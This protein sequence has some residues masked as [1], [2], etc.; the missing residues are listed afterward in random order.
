[1]PSFH[2]PSWL[3]RIP[4]SIA[5]FLAILAWI[6][7]PAAIA[8]YSAWSYQARIQ[9][10]T[11]S[12]GAGVSENVTNF[13]VLVRLT[14]N[15]F[16]F[17]QAMPDGADIRFED[18]DGTALSYQIE[19]WDATNKL[20]E[21]WVK[22]PQV[23]GNSDR[24]YILMYWGRV[25]ATS[26]SS[27]S[28]VF[29]N[30][31]AVWHLGESPGASAPQFTD[32]S[33]NV[34]HGTAQGGATGDS[35]TAAVG[36]GYKLNGSSKY[37]S[38]AVSFA[39]P[40]TF[41]TSA[42]FKTTTASGG[43]IVGF[44][45][46]QTGSGGNRDRH[47]WMDNNGKLNFGTYNSAYQVLSYTGAAYNDGAWHQVATRISGSGKFIFVDGVQVAS[48][49]V[50]T[51]QNYT[52]YWR[53]GYVDVNGGSW[54]PTP[55]SNYLNGTLDEVWVSH[56][57]VSADFIKLAYQTQKPASTVLTYPNTALSTWTY[58]TKVYVNTTASGANVS[59]DQSN[60]P[61]L[62]RLTAA[63][64]NFSQ[65]NS[66]GS[67]LRFADSAGSLLSYEIERWDATNKQ[68]EIWVLLSTVKGNNNSQWFRIYWG[69][70]TATSLSSGGAVFQT[71]N[72]YA[73]VWH[74]NESSGNLL[75]ATV[76]GNSGAY[77]GNVPNRVDGLIGKAQDFDG[78]GD[79][80]SAGSHAS[81]DVSASD[82][83]TLSAWVRR[84]GA[85]VSGDA[86]GIVTKLAWNSGD[87]RN[88][89]LQYFNDGQGVSFI[90]SADG[91]GPGETFL[92]S[93]YSLTNGIWY[94]LAAVADNATLKIYVNGSQVASQAYT[95]GIFGHASS[96]ARIGLTDDNGSSD[97][98]YWNGVIDEAGISRTDRA[99]DW[100]KL[101]YETQKAGSSV[102]S[103]GARSG[104]FTKSLQLNF[105]TTSSGANVSG[106]VANIPILVRLTSSNFDFT[107]VR[108]DAADLR[109]LD[110]DG[111][112]LYHEVA[113]WD[114][115]NKTGK[116][117]VKVPQV[118]GNSTTDFITAYYG[119]ATCSG[120]AWAVKDS[121]W[122]SYLSVF[123]LNA[124]E[125]KAYDAGPLGNHGVF[126]KNQPII[127]GITG[128]N[129]AFFDGSSDY[130]AVPNEAQYDVTTNVTASAWIKVSAF[131]TAYQAV[132]GKGDES[133][134]LLRNNT[135]N[136]MTFAIN[137]SGG[138]SRST[139]TSVND[140]QWHQVVGTYD[141]ANLRIYLD[142]VQE[143]VDMAETGTITNNS[144][145]LWI[146]SQVDNPSRYWNGAISEMRIAN[147]TAVQSA[148]FIKLSYQNQKATDA[149]LSTPVTAASFTSSKVFRFNTTASGANVSGDVYNFPLLLRFTDATLI[150]AVQSG[151]PDIRFLDAD[152][153][154]WLDYQVERWDQA[155]DLAEVW[156]KVP[157]VDG[158]SAGD[159]ITMYYNDATNGAV[160]DGQCGACVFAPANAFSGVWHLNENGNNTAGGY[161]DATGNGYHGT[162]TNMD[163]DD[164][165]TA[166]AG[167]G[168]Q[169]NNAA[170]G[171][172]I[173][174]GTSAGSSGSQ[175]V[176]FWAVATA[177]AN[178]I[179]VDKNPN[180]ASGAGWCFKFRSD[181]SVWYRIGSES[182]HTDLQKTSGYAA[183]TWVHVTG[184]FDLATTTGRLYINGGLQVT[185]ASLAYRVNNTG[186]TLRIGYPSA[187]TTEKFPGKVD[188]LQ[189]STVA[190]DSNWVKLTYQTQRSDATPLFNPNVTDF[191]SSRK[192]TFNTTLTGANVMGDVENFPL[193]VRLTGSAL[194]DA[195]Q[196][197]YDD[198]RFLDGDGKTWLQYQVER[199]DKTQDSA[200]V[201][202]LV[203]KVDGNSDR[204]FITLYYDDVTNAAVPNGQCAACV[205][206]TASAVTAAWHM[207][208]NGGATV[209]EAI[210][211][212][213]DGTYRSTTTSENTSNHTVGGTIGN[214]LDFQGGTAGAGQRNNFIHA[215]TVNR[216]FG[217]VSH[218]VRPSGIRDMV[219]YYE[220][221]NSGENGFSGGNVYEH[222]LGAL[223]TGKYMAI[224]QDGSGTA[225]SI[226]GGTAAANTWAHVAMTWN[227]SDSLRL[228]VDGVKVA[229]GNLA[230]T[231]F[232]GF[233]TTMRQV[234]RVPTGDDTRHWYGRIDEIQVSN[235][236]RSADWLK[237]AYETQRSSGNLFWNNRPGP[238]N[239]AT[240]TATPGS[241]SIS[242]SWTIPVSDSAN[243]DSVGL[244][245]KYSG[246]PDSVG[247]TGQ[248]KVVLLPKTD[249]VYAYPAT[250]P[251]TYTFALAVRNGSGQWSPFTAT[252]TDTVQQMGSTGFTDT[253]YVDSAIGSDANSCAQAQSPATPK[254]T[255]GNADDC[256][257]TSNDTLVIRVL[258][259]TYA[260]DAIFDSD[261]DPIVVASFDNNSRAVFSYPSGS[262]THNSVNYKPTLL[263]YNDVTVRNLDILA[264][265]NGGTG[266]MTKNTADHNNSIEGCR[267][268]NNGNTKHAWGIVLP[269]TAGNNQH[270]ANNIIHQPTSIGILSEKDD[271]I[272]I[273]NNTL[274]G[275][276]SAGGKGIHFTTAAVSADM[277]IT[278]NILYNWDYGIQ[279]VSN[280]AA[281]GVVSNN[282][283][284]LVTS[285]REL[286]T[287]TDANKVIKDPLFYSTD[288]RNP[289]GFKLLPGS[290]ALDAGT[291]TRD[292]GYSAKTVPYDLWGT[293]RAQG[294]AVDI[295][296]YE[297]TG[298]TPTP[299]AAFDTLTNVVS[300]NT[301]IVKNSKWKL[302]WDMARG[303]GI[304]GFYDMTGDTTANLTASSSLLFDVRI[305]GYLASTQTSNAIAP[306]FYERTRARSVIRQRLALSPS[307]DLNVWYTVH[308]SGH[309]YIQSEISNLSGGTLDV[310]AVQYFLKLGAATALTQSAGS[311]ASIS[312]KNGYGFLNT[313]SKDALLAVTRDLDEGALGASETWSQV[314]S[315]AGSTDS[316]GF[317]IADMTDLPQWMK[318]HH[319]FLLYVGDGSLDN[320]KASTLNADAYNPSPVT[321]SAGS[322]LHERSW[323]D[324]LGGHWN[325]DEGGGTTVKDRSINYTNDA[326]ITSGTWVSGK[327]GGALRFTTSSVATVS[328]HDALEAGQSRMYM[329]WVKPDFSAMGADAF[330]LSKGTGTSDGW[331]FRRVSGANQI[332][333]Q[334]GAV[335]VSSPTL[336]TNTWV[337]L[338]ASI[339]GPRTVVLYVNG[340]MAASSTTAATLTA[341]ANALR[342]GEN[343]GGGAADRFAGDIDDVRIYHSIPP[344]GQLQAIV[345]QGFSAQYGHYHLRAD[346]NNR[347]VA[348]L[349]GTT[350]QTR[351]QPAFKIDNWF[352]PKTPKHVY[353]NGVRLVPNVDFVADSVPNASSTWDFGPSLVL[354]LN[355]VLTGSTQTLFID[356]NDS[357]GYLGTAGKMKSLT[358]SAVANDKLIVKNFADTVFGSA[359]SGQWY[360]ELDLNGWT[361][362]TASRVT[363][364]G[365]GEF[366]SWKA[367][368][369]SPN[370]AVSSATQ[371]VGSHFEAGRALATMKFHN[372]ETIYASGKG[373]AGPANITYTL[374]DSSS[375]RLSLTL[376]A[377]TIQGTGR[378]I[379]LTKRWTVYPTGRI[380]GS[381]LISSSDFAL[382]EPQVR[383]ITRFNSAAITWANATSTAN[384]R[385]ALSGG[386][387]NFHS[388]AGALLSVKSA[389]VTSSSPGTLLASTLQSSS[390]S[391]GADYLATRLMMATTLFEATDDPITINFVADISRD[392]TDSATADSLMKDVQTPATLTAVGAGTANP[393]D[394]LDFNTTAADGFAEGDGAY[395]YTAGA[396]TAHFKFVNTVTHFNP[397]FRIKSWT[398]STLPEFVI[399]DNQT[400]VKDYQY[401]AYVNVSSNELI[402]QFNKTFTPGTHLFYISHKTGLAVTLNR[403]EALG[404][405]GVDSLAWST[406]SEF[407]NLGFNVWRRAAPK[408]PLPDSLFAGE[409]ADSA[410]SGEDTLPSHHLTA[411]QLAVLG[412]VRLNAKL[413][414]GAPGGSSATTRAYRFVD[415]TAAFG[416]AYEYL[417]EAV[418]F[419]GSKVQYGPRAATPGNPL[420][421]AL[422][423]NYPNPF[424]PVTTLRFSLKE[425]ARISL[426][427]YDARGRLVRTLIRP[428]KAMLP[429]RYRLLWDARDDGGFQV[430][431]GQY[432][433]RFSVPKYSKTRKMILVQ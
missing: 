360:T 150:D 245:V 323:Q 44:A 7:P 308:A 403:F 33:G 69:K 172:Y 151:A 158:N 79:Y 341:N 116:V 329:L 316:V 328:D 345:G 319:H 176:S 270:I 120:N 324:Q 390:T 61:L 295:G 373:Y 266:I 430:P 227:T 27:G 198:I 292:D 284:H 93:S 269:G 340:V 170:D 135:G 42:W 293:A 246:K 383:F 297:G 389:N 119:C 23:D 375:T 13:P 310:D 50:T 43:G 410:G 394:A 225:V 275:D 123:H 372:G 132:L 367:A 130:V 309:V 366:N 218:W 145:A 405:D 40:T 288:I 364:T 173:A 207:A 146:G 265:Q 347:V 144:D 88:Y 152:G 281:T 422:L 97:R 301:V 291:T 285:G 428:D 354:Q 398:F 425:K 22:V 133:F 307:L 2:P 95:G 206:G 257:N 171:E 57:E 392:F 202:V 344:I 226:N 81:L 196:N 53:A 420:E 185:D 346:N 6:L 378:N 249:S 399:V 110:K 41:T 162:G 298:Y 72:N 300:G 37:V 391:G 255:V 241:G 193:L 287:V 333:F 100:I 325:F 189:I 67:D 271:H 85:S 137:T 104:D 51:P 118:D 157:K 277:T 229:S 326:T 402:L 4:G 209:D 352:A 200:E 357:S 409:A 304:A 66:D 115:G 244:W 267:I 112:A 239:K 129:A 321:V 339:D 414:P 356:D 406:E 397:A 159:F 48:D 208:D 237:L 46:N 82:K 368:A 274:I 80:A 408:Q 363:D 153:V 217:T 34:N 276:G 10:N 98:Q 259:G 210:G 350:A 111:T 427:V 76:N 62:V 376:A 54:S 24:D 204:D 268:Y 21:V 3:C 411:E 343:A 106:N 233:A 242:L 387:L 365:F 377:M 348:V 211:S 320:S 282:L 15:N 78:N 305:D 165:V 303:G 429:G 125:D 205:F 184:T 236:V 182:A 349:N 113:E 180:D 192:L 260:G 154:T 35:L 164:D 149:L 124:P 11:T 160:P 12:S 283:F 400:L 407:E 279:T 74:L 163:S 419:S 16:I 311:L 59:T 432:F 371:L 148:N 342:M 91:T 127:N 299:T 9:F 361:T 418:D 327:V 220:G 197:D 256:A 296:A 243:A 18:P 306:V 415:R 122:N 178:Q 201:W 223:G 396:G 426:I 175:T 431:S 49:G 250:Y 231:T 381:F 26:E 140:G 433:Y 174:A 73:G 14:S 424:N 335:S 386:D 20:A 313:A 302:V 114:K 362:P 121:V 254:L 107:A 63:N 32:A 70:G 315:I 52:G 194:V 195:V 168:S 421:T 17:S 423:P 139:S 355:K 330:L 179:P 108:D 186:T 263:L 337:H 251:M 213:N 155:N 247:A 134:R 156:V 102:V 84:D 238:N 161:A 393:S 413:L 177:A 358:L 312:Y 336:A 280:T 264:G 203:P 222:H 224:Y 92:T 75:D 351:V 109:F 31:K 65:A 382:D 36:K 359:T 404:G 228:Y 278:N 1:M 190:R 248:T 331:H 261:F 45:A 212:T 232:S 369:V 318:R 77:A 103:V 71:A 380:F 38:S 25:S 322:L 388:L 395:V 384:G 252:S 273:M 401:N 141:G 272:N 338:A 56:T 86:E 90:V 19:R 235:Q 89:A 58:N 143:D 117:W 253:I 142:G 136:T 379:T 412:Y 290:P 417:L 199:W 96:A 68:A 240:L 219:T 370:L 8:D 188:E 87:Y 29:G 262:F 317:S 39:N 334:V 147:S 230:A 47:T 385:A 60:F 94:H 289:N 187:A 128:K 30:Y 332:K 314:G 234:G 214:A 221:S 169:F 215:L 216:A 286:T 181:N 101:S 83:V 258:P 99:A 138:K 374:V 191:V 64:F 416:T 28:G 105:N 166:V 126:N 353:L 167:L 131:T 55:T 294:A 5:R 183:G